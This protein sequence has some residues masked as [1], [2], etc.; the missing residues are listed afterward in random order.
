MF[1]YRRA[2]AS[3]ALF[4]VAIGLCARSARMVTVELVS[5]VPARTFA[6]TYQVH[7]PA[8]AEIVASSHVWIPIPQADGYQEI[9]ALHIDSPVA[10]SQGRDPEYGNTFAMF[11]PTPKQITAGFDVALHF[12][13][14]QTGRFEI[15]CTQLC[16]LGH[17]NMKAYLSVLTQEDFDKWMKQKISEQ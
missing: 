3:A 15:L 9:H 8:S 2:A 13:A 6:F 14:T 5:D 16:G 7:V 10:Y 4:L 11:T 17:Y 12:T 1:C